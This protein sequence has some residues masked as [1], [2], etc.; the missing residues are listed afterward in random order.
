MS[1]LTEYADISADELSKEAAGY[2]VTVVDPYGRLLSYQ[3]LQGDSGG[4]QTR[5]SDLASFSNFTD[6]NV[7]YP[8]ITALGSLLQEGQCAPPL[9]ATQYEFSPY[10]FGSW[11]NGVSA[12]ASSQY[13]GSDLSN[14]QPKDSNKCVVHYDNL[15]Y[16]LGTS[17]NVFAGVCEVVQPSNSTDAPL[18]D[19]LEG[20]VDIVKEP[21]I[22]DLFARYP[23]P[24]HNYTRSSLVQQDKELF[25]ADGGLSDQNN[26]IWPFIQNAARSIDV[27]I[28]N[29]NSADTGDNF[30]NGTE[31]RQ[32]Y[33]N[34]QAAGLTKMPFIP[35]VSVFVDEGL[36]KRATF[37]GC[38]ET[39][40]TFIVYLP[41]VN[42]TYPANQPTA[43]LQYSK[44]ATDGMIS[45]AN[46]I[47]SQNGDEGWPLCL[48]C[49]IKSKDEG[50][51]EG[52]NACFDKYCYRGNGTST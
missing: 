5:L 31:I 32:T 44:D 15:G 37:F 28:V 11:D 43:R 48:A 25:L 26:P 36:N 6:H 7:P 51:P 29:D 42:Y 1:G 24:F 21:E 22:E 9:N 38:N 16:V 40:T 27:I 35:D 33:M 34:A 45:N 4:V 50:L 47:A 2:E 20:L 10:E 18:V 52:C 17:S 46:L 12:F 8:V 49:A 13:L 23:N 19:V 39:D 41:M 3:L 14:G 30:P